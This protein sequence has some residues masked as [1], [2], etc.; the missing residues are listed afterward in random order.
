[1]TISFPRWLRIICI[2]IA[3]LVATAG[4]LA[5]SIW[6]YLH[7]SV[8]RTDRIVY[9]RRG[10]KDL[11]LDVL[12]PRNPN[13]LGIALMVSGSWKSKGPGETAVWLA[14]PLLRSG[15]TVFHVC[16][17]SQPASTVMEIIDDMHRGLR[18]IRHNARGFGI[19]PARIGVTGGSSGGHLSLMLATRGGPG[20]PNASD[21][22]D[23]ESSAVQAVAVFFPV[24]D[25]LNLGPS[26]ENP[27]DGGPPI[28][29]VRAFGPDSK[30][31]TVWKRIGRESSPIYFV[32]GT[33][34]PTL[35]H[36]GD[37]DTLVPLEQS[38]R[39]QHRAVEIGCKV[40]LV[41]HPGRKHGWPTMIFDERDFVRWFD[42][43]LRRQTI[44]G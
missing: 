19:D 42:R 4:A 8:E 16:H 39:F 34:P 17:I 38:Q 24:T 21:P 25:L 18:F 6:L 33:L 11:T 7:P 10:D 29:Y 28:N 22:I 1:M 15:Y 20:D 3:I 14:A 32:N 2:T 12:R 44:T 30:N 36:H 43:H 37:T 35:I 41:V 5:G 31:M 40:K 13:G 27:G 26:T 9:G 23:R